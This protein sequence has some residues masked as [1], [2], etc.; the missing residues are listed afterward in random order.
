LDNALKYGK[1]NP[2]ITISIFD[3][4]QYLELRVSD[5]GIGIANEYRFKIFEQF[6]G[7]LEEINII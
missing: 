6:F 1:T 3:R 2:Q 4:S 5:D 7:Y